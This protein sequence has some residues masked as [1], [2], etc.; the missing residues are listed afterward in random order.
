[1]LSKKGENRIDSQVTSEDKMPLELK[2][3]NV[4]SY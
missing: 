4:R 1:M 2:R 3:T